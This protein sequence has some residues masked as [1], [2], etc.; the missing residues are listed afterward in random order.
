MR[1]FLIASLF[2][3]LLLLPGC[4][5]LLSMHPLA[6]PAT[7]IFD[8][9]L[10]GQ[11]TCVDKDCK[12]TVLIRPNPAPKDSYDIVWIPGE[13]DGLSFKLT[14]WRAPDLNSVTDAS[15]PADLY[16]TM[17]NEAFK[18]F[19]KKYLATLFVDKP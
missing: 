16:E 6:T 14:V 5:D 19:M 1:H 18:R 2:A 17:A 15:T 11:W 8:K 9:S 4:G 3:M 7:Q 12:G 10:I 13:A